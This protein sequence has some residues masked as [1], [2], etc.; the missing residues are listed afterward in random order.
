VLSPA[1]DLISQGK[2][3]LS[4]GSDIYSEVT[5]A[6]FPNGLNNTNALNALPTLVC[7]AGKIGSIVNRVSDIVTAITTDIHNFQTSIANTRDAIVRCP[8]ET[9]ADL[10]IELGNIVTTSAECALN[11]NE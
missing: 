8:R 11:E 3:G 10:V 9:V 4:M 6:C 1:F 2:K 5:S 7:V